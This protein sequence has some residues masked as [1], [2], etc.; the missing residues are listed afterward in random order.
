MEQRKIG[1]GE[2]ISVTLALLRERLGLSVAATL[3]IAA[4]YSALDLAEATGTNLV[5]TLAVSVFGQYAFTQALLADRIPAQ[6]K[7][8]YTTL[9]IV[10][11]LSGLG[12]LLG[13]I[14][15]ILP[16]IFLIAR[17]SIATPFVVAGGL[18]G[19]DALK[20][21]WRATE[22]SWPALFAL[23][24]IGGVVLILAVGGFFVAA[25]A[26]GLSELS[27]FVVIPTNIVV[28]GMTVLVWLFAVAV[29]QHLLPG[30]SE[31]TEV[32]G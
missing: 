23:V 25:E 16:G 29:Y 24:L 31:F 3:A 13:I 7:P 12:V 19:T 21:S 32:F 27:P 8:R 4:G 28:G 17:W 6:T 11:L 10:G 30:E 18:G 14:L 26:W 22:K 2:A 1:L 15:L 5:A 9:F 20:A